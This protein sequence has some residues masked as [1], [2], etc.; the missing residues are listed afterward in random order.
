M[1][2]LYIYIPI[3][4]A[5]I[6]LSM[7]RKEAILGLSGKP[8]SRTSTAGPGARTAPQIEAHCL[9]DPR[10]DESQTMGSDIPKTGLL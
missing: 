9:E 3:Y 2:D 1:I 5:S 7:F 8:P 4:L 10:H 6:Y